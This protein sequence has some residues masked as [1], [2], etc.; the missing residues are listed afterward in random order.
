[1]FRSTGCDA[2]PRPPAHRAAGGSRG[3]GALGHGAAG[4][5]LLARRVPA[6]PW[7]SATAVLLGAWVPA[8]HV[9]ARRLLRPRIR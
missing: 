2:S 9:I 8:S 3:C 4:A 7:A 1:M 5:E 6:H